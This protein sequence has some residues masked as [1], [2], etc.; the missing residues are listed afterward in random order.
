M[1]VRSPGRNPRTW[2]RISLRERH[3]PS[4]EYHHV[5]TCNY[6]SYL[7]EKV[8]FAVGVTPSD[9]TLVDQVSPAVGAFEALGVP[10]AVQHLEDESVQNEAVA[11]GTSWDSRCNYKN[12][13]EL[14][15]PLLKSNC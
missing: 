12:I 8:F 11:A 9:E 1:K 7:P 10:R 6:Y 15:H 5:Y 3:G 2:C 14:K 13:I 4:S